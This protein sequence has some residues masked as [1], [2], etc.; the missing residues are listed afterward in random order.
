[1]LLPKHIFLSGIGTNVGKTI[2]SAIL[3]EA[4]EAD[5]WKPVQTGFEDGKDRDTIKNLISNSQTTIHQS[6]YE[7]LLPASPNIAADKE[8]IKIES[9]KLVL[10]ITNN[11]LIIEGA[12]GLLVP[13]NDEITTL[14]FIAENNLDVILIVN[15]YLGC[16]NHTLL[17]LDVLKSRKINLLIGVFNGFANEAVKN[18]IQKFSDCKW[19]GVD[20]ASTID[21][22]FISAQAQKIRDELSSIR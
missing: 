18:T 3:C 4:L 22:N 20:M 21:K 14:D 16:I 11:T 13:L 1:M 5:Y 12:G 6:A 2:V 10:P 8:N 15:D 9:E 19:I 7:L 17:S